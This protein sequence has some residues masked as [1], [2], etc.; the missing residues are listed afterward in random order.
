MSPRLFF[1]YDAKSLGSAGGY[2]MEG[3]G[4]NGLW[5]AGTALTAQLFYEIKLDN[6]IAGTWVNLSQL[7]VPQ[8]HILCYLLLYYLGR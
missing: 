6:R 1:P 5:K 8:L 4:R 2:G 7:L 3:N